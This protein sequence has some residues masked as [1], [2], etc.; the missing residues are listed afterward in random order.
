ML[1]K[2]LIVS[3]ALVVVLSMVLKAGVPATRNASEPPARSFTIYPI[4]KVH[5]RGPATTIKIDQPY[6]DA[7]AGLDGF[8]HVWVFWWFDRNDTPS[9]RRTL[10]VYPR[11]NVQNP[12][13]GVFATRSPRRPN[14]IALTLCKIQSVGPGVVHIDQIDAFDETPV[15]DLKPYIPRYDRAEAVRLPKWLTRGKGE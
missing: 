8:S 7:L 1:T 14:L 13:T 9:Q 12:L 10:K 6:Q 15:V 2:L 4:G 5:K 3:A 11:G